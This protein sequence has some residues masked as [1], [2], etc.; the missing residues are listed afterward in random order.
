MNR[1][2][3]KGVWF[4]PKARVSRRGKV[5]QLV[6]VYATDYNDV[7]WNLNGGPRGTGVVEVD[8]PFDLQ[9]TISRVGSIDPRHWYMDHVPTPAER[10]RDGDMA[11]EAHNEMLGL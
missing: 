7:V 3:V 1:I 4:V 5:R 6:A 8:N 11:A 10:R 2:K 9:A